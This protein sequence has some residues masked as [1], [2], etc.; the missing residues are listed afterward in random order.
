M[1]SFKDQRA[2]IAVGEEENPNFRE[3]DI[4]ILY[5]YPTATCVVKIGMTQEI[6]GINAKDV[7]ALIILTNIVGFDK[8]KKLIFLKT[9][10]LLIN[11][12]IQV[13]TLK[14]PVIYGMLTVVVQTT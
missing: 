10:K 9:M 5:L 1:K 7:A 11:Y 12:F 13:L 4:I 3:K 8:R 14:R 6:V 2:I